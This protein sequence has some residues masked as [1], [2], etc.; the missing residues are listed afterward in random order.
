MLDRCKYLLCFELVWDSLVCWCLWVV[1]TWWYPNTN[2]VL[3]FGLV[4][5][6]LCLLQFEILYVNAGW[7]MFGRVCYVVFTSVIRPSPAFWLL[8]CLSV[9]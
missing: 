9:V 1:C 6:D 4:E 5:M 8:S 7:H 2:Y 3:V